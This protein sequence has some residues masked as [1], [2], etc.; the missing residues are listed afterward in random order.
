[1]SENFTDVQ[2]QRRLLECRLMQVA[3]SYEL[4]DALQLQAWISL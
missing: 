4:P 1:M 3:D 2:R